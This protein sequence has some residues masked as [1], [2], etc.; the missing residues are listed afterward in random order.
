VPPNERQQDAAPRHSFDNRFGEVDA[1]RNGVNV[2]EDT[3]FTEVVTKVIIQTASLG[4][5]VLPP[6]TDEDT[7]APK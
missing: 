3:A 4:A 5:R 1:E 2:H 6:V 7:A